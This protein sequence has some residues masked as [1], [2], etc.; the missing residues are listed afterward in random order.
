MKLK[1]SKRSKN[2]FIII[3]VVIVY[4]AEIFGIVCLVKYFLDNLIYILGFIFVFTFWTGFTLYAGLYGLLS[5]PPPP[6]IIQYAEFPVELVYEIE[7]EKY[8]ISDILICEYEGWT[9]TSGWIGKERC[10]SDRFES[11]IDEIVI[12]DDGETKVEWEFFSAAEYMGDDD[13]YQKKYYGTDPKFYV[14][15]ENN[16]GRRIFE[17]ELLS[18]FGITIIE[19]KMPEPI[20]N[21]FSNNIKDIII[22]WLTIECK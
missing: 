10:W 3:A 5:P 20:E 16:S 21:E 11:G 4:I 17:D 2:I 9:T 14:T 12:F 19:Y 6:P 7:D 1:L 8:E 13:G 18:E 22:H 15:S